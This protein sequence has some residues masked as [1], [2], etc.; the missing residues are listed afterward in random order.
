MTFPDT[1]GGGGQKTASR[2]LCLF[3][4]FNLRQATFVDARL[5][6][7]LHTLFV[8]NSITM[9]GFQSN[10]P[11]ASAHDVPAQ[12]LHTARFRRSVKVDATEDAEHCDEISGLRIALLIQTISRIISCI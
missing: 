6:L 7:T 12:L 10:Q 11:F 4:L 1:F 5:A 9:Q 2:C 8:C 3:S